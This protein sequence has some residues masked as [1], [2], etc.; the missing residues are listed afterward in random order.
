MIWSVAYAD[1][2]FG[3]HLWK[4]SRLCERETRDQFL[5]GFWTVTTTLGLVIL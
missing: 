2:A 4:P 1:S 3:L 5:R